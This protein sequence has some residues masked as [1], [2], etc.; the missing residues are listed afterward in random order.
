MYDTLRE[1]SHNFTVNAS[2]HEMNFDKLFPYTAY[3]I[4]IL[5]FT[6][7]GEGNASTVLAIR[8]NEDGKPSSVLSIQNLRLIFITQI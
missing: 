7:K 1:E 5:A 2:V 4:R 3:E 8:T 6:S